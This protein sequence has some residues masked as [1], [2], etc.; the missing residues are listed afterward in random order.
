MLKQAYRLFCV[1][2]C[3]GYTG[4]FAADSL[5]IR[6]GD[7][8]E[9]AMTRSLGANRIAGSL[10]L[11]QAERDLDLQRSNP[12]LA[13]DRQ[14]VD[15]N[16]N[17]ETQITLGKTFEMPWVSLKRRAA[18]SDR[19]H[20][21]ELS[22]EEQRGLLL[23][24]LKSGY[25]TLQLLDAHL[26][27]LTH[28]R[29]V[30]TDASHVATTRHSEGHLSGVENH[31][32]QM[33]VISLQ[34]EHQRALA[35]R[36][37]QENQWRTMLGGT[38]D[39]AISLVTPIDFRPVSL[40]PAVDYAQR[41]SERPGYTSRLAYQQALAKQAG[42]E[43]SRIVPGFNLY[44][45]YKTIDPD[46]DGYVVGVSLSLP[47]LN[48]NRAKVKRYDIERR[49]A[50]TE[51]TRYRTQQLGRLESLVVAVNEAKETLAMSHAHFQEDAEALD[52]LLFS[53]E[54]GWLTLSELLNG[55][56]IEIAGLNDYYNLMVR[57]YQNIFELET[58]TGQTLVQFE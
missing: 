46:F 42:A 21:A 31:L 24:E 54:E 3:V 34:T 50:E 5:T 48:A 33:T 51:T 41:F 16:G 52:D 23:S 53:Y 1:V 43:R 19:L 28:I 58:I 17:S 56:Q 57:Y 2:V 30:L 40:A 22:A 55:V 29:E 45:G 37:E 44:G 14:D 12:E 15:G 10:G 6:Y 26:S 9:W 32:I 11:V 4:T 49:L 39:Q 8:D 35:G 7:L 25:T 18:W 38:P 47:F 27:R 13:I 20:A 36:R